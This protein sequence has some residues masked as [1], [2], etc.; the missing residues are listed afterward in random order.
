MFLRGQ[1]TNSFIL[2]W[3]ILKRF[4]LLLSPRSQVLV[5][6]AWSETL[7]VSLS[8]N[9]TSFDILTILDVPPDNSFLY[10]FDAAS[11]S[12]VY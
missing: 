2:V 3:G 11:I 10:D 12:S 6:Q 1:V 7:S 5:A 8:A 9:F 4:K